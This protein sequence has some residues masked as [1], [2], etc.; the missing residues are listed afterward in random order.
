MTFIRK[1][2]PLDDPLKQFLDDAGEY[3][4]HA[5]DDAGTCH[6]DCYLTLQNDLKA[7]GEDQSKI[8]KAHADNQTCIEKCP[9]LV[10][11]FQL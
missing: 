6:S 1:K 8:E 4:E 3:F 5:Y 11:P 9:P 7:A 10:P 2:S